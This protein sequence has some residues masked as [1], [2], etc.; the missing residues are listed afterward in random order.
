VELPDDVQGDIQRLNDM[1]RAQRRLST[2]LEAVTELVQRTVPGCDAASISLTVEES[3]VTGASPSQ[4]AIEAD[5]VQYRM[6]EGPCLSAAEEQAVIRVDALTQDEHFEHFAP[7]AIELGVESVLSVPLVTGGR[8]VGSVNL[9]SR[10]PHAFHDDDAS[11]ISEPAAYAAHLIASS[12]FYEAS[13]DLLARLVEAVRQADQV[14]MAI[15][16]FI[17][18]QGLTPGDAWQHLRDLADRDGVS[19][20]ELAQRLVD[21]HERRAGPLD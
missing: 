14:E 8:T 3:M 19:I 15:G 16:L 21:E 2:K 12:R 20:V 7:G 5:L 9:Y 13:A 18:A 11:R 6:G 10:T 4:L 17:F 1:F